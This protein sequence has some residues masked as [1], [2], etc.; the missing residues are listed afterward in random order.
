[1]RCSGIHNFL[2]ASAPFTP[3]ERLFLANGLRF[4][5]T[6]PSKNPIYIKHYFN[7]LTR[8]WPRFTRSLVHRIVHEQGSNALPYLPKFTVRN[9]LRSQIYAERQED[10]HRTHLGAQFTLLDQYRNS[11]LNMLQRSA[12]LDTH[13]TLM[14]Q[15]RPNH[16]QRDADFVRC[17]MSD[18]SITIKPADKNLGMVLID[19][20]WYVAELQRMLSDR[21]T[22]SPLS[23]FR[24]VT[25]GVGRMR[26][27]V[28]QPY[29]VDIMQKELHDKLSTLVDRHTATLALWNP[30]HSNQLLKYLRTAVTLNT[31][32]LPGI[33]LLIKVH[34][35]RLCGR[36]IVPS[37]HWL[38]TPASKVVDHL[39]QEVLREAKLEHLVK[40]T[41]SFVVE[42]ERISVPDCDTLLLTADIATLYTNIDTDLGLR[43]V[44]EF[45][46]ER[47]VSAHH[48][49]LIM[50]MLEFVMRNSWL[51][52]GDKVFHQ[53]D[54]TAMGTSCAPTYANIVVYMLER[55]VLADM[56]TVL[57][58][59]RRFLDDVFVVV[60]RSAVAE[61]MHRMNTLHPKLRFEFVSHPRE[62]SFL[63]LRIHKGARFTQCG[64]FDL[65]VHQ[66]KMNLYLYIPYNSFH[67]DAMKRSFIQ[68]ELMRY[69]RNSSDREEYKRLKQTFFQRL[70]DRGYPATFLLPLFESIWYTDRHYFLWPSATLHEHPQLQSHP[71]RSQCLI[72]RLDRRKQ[73]QTATASSD[74][75]LQP[76]VFVI[77]YSPLSHVLPTRS[78]L[79][80]LWPLIQQAT[81]TPLPTPIIAYQSSANLMKTLVYQRDRLLETAR[82][83]R[84]ATPA[85]LLRQLSLRSFLNP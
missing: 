13:R 47:K 59:Y 41:K 53:I 68:T 65:S 37:T 17:L 44:R 80:H 10:E 81:N 1:M 51:G 12:A 66:K 32:V 29:N 67:T 4:V 26:K 19:T 84:L 71:P 62:A 63:D 45:L 28:Q 48:S 49:E 46:N 18:A 5:C 70:R 22:Y 31:C 25:R 42:L 83:A 9:A 55:V 69:I 35:V 78:L 36:P 74:P 58:L 20:S 15:Q 85:P 3:F 77:P 6:P 50:D 24:T 21:V 23:R 43:L 56:R 33:Y 7:D 8:G 60:Q 30:V 61:F 72:K 54:G 34:K 73:R 39:L 57:H 79:R 76:A 64:I 40:D 16:S 27:E 75:P 2:T 82:K 14:Q 38:T 11:T 52:F